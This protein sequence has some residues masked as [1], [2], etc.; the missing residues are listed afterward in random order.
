ML[1][2]A[3]ISLTLA[4]VL[5]ALLAV[6]DMPTGTATRLASPSLCLSNARPAARVSAAI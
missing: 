3:F 6:L 4:L 5:G 2:I 1:T